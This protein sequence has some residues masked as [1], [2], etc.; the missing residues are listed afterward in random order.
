M[1]SESAVKTSAKVEVQPF[2]FVFPNASESQSSNGGNA[3]A[4]QEAKAQT[5]KREREAYDRGFR[6]GEARGRS[7]SEA[8][9]VS[10]QKSVADTLA[11][12]EQDRDDYFARVETE[13]VQLSLAIARKILHRE[14]QVDPLLL[15]GLVHVALEKLDAGTRVRLRASPSEIHFWNEYFAQFGAIGNV[16][17]LVGDASLQPGECALETE[18]GSTQISLDT[19]LKEV[20][21]GF[22]DLLEQRPR[23]RA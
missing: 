3:P 22:F 17:D 11:K 13:V 12:F 14:A 4:V 20:E 21:L 8:L 19:Q 16:P 6:E 15:T 18:V 5:D 10:F 2:Q 23:A 7:A 1:S 9:I